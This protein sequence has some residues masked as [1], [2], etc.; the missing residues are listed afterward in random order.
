MHM[1]VSGPATLHLLQSFKE[2]WDKER[3]WRN[4]ET[5]T[6]IR[7]RFRRSSH[8]QE[9]AVRVTQ[10]LRSIDDNSAKFEN[11]GRPG[12]V[13]V[14]GSWV[15][16]SIQSGVVEVIRNAQEFLYIESQYFAGSSVHWDCETWDVG[17]RI[18]NIIDNAVNTVPYEII[19]RI[20]QKIRLRQQFC[21]YVVMSMLPDIEYE[22]LLYLIMAD[23]TYICSMTIRMMYHKIGEELRA[24]GSCLH[25]TD[26]LV[27]LCMGKQ[28]PKPTYVHSKMVIADDCYIVAG[29]ANLIDRS[30]AGNQD[31]EIAILAQQLTTCDNQVMTTALHKLPRKLWANRRFV[32]SSTRSQGRT[33][34]RHSQLKELANEGLR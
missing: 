32:P 12:L 20:I 18:F 17:D 28:E 2:R 6:C 14:G 26:Y 23:S 19:K 22:N 10:V 31:T 25:P 4:P 3:E 34:E 27:F 24:V 11:R 16:T 1:R 30:L 13:Q 15:D 29:S 9:E 33:L 21:V 8:G 5:S 7:S